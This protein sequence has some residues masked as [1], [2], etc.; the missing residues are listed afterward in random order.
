MCIRDRHSFRFKDTVVLRSGFIVHHGGVGLITGN[1]GEGQI[2]E[3]RNLAAQL[4]E[5]IGGAHL[6]YLL[7]ADMRL[8]PVNKP[9]NSHAVL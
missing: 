1:G 6:R 7:L 4:L 3:S 5:I 9:G 2:Q 8:E